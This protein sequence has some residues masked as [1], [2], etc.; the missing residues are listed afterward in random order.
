M[1][2]MNKWTTVFSDNDVDEAYEV[3]KP[4]IGFGWR[5]SNFIDRSKTTKDV[6]KRGMEKWL[7]SINDWHLSYENLGVRIIG[8]T[9]L[10]CG[11]LTEKITE[12]DGSVRVVKVR[13]SSTWIKLDGKWKL[14]MFH[15]DSQFNN[16]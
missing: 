3:V 5:G 13:Y 6:F 1:K 8:D 2:A 15:R 10:L 12:L 9:G 4:S 16:L 11:I 7:T 14:V